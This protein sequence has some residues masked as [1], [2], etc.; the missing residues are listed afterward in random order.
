MILISG[1]PFQQSNIESTNS[2]E[3]MIIQSMSEAPEVY[4]YEYVSEFNFEVQLRKNIIDSAGV[5]HQSEVQFATFNT[6]RSN[7]EYWI[8][9]QPGGLMLRQ[10]V[11]PSEGIED[12]F[13]NS[14]QY[15]FECA[16]AMLIILYHA[17]LKAIGEYAFNRLFPDLYIYS[18]HADPDLGIYPTYT[19]NFI[20]GDIVYFRNPD[21]DP[22]IAHWRG[23]NAVVLEN[24]L[25]FGHGIGVLTA[26][27]MIEALNRTRKPGATQSAY[28]TNLIVRPSFKHLEKFSNLQRG[29]SVRKYQSIVI[30]HNESSIPFDRYK[31]LLFSIYNRL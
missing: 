10:G 13:K 3:K 2:T 19:D 11:K 24:G 27:Q 29:Y 4:S 22:Q 5:M 30:Q 21:V 28:L 14:A 17:V 31:F 6:T 16:G 18:W 15:G 7:P 26:Q 12:I 8:V 23:E 1:R 25:Y 9:T 20:L